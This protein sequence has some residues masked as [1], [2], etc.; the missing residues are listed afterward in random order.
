MGWTGKT[1]ADVAEAWRLL[2][3]S[4]A[5]DS[6]KLLASGAGTRRLLVAAVAARAGLSDSALAIARRVRDSLPAGAPSSAVDYGEAYVHALLG[7]DDQAITLL[8][9]YLRANPALRGQVRQSPWFATLRTT[10]RF[11]A[12]TAP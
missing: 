10:P 7:H 4:E 9:S 3:A 12:I 2:A 11:Q 6:A 5:R 8:E 1:R